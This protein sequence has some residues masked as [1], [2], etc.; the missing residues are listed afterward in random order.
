MP[1]IIIS[2]VILGV[3]F[4]LALIGRGLLVS[5]AFRISWKWGLGVLL[6]FGPVAFRLSYP[7]DAQPSRIF[8]LAALPCFLYFLVSG[9]GLPAM[10]RPFSRRPPT[11]AKSA[12]GYA[13]EK[14]APANKSNNVFTSMFQHGPTIEER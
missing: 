1:V 10:S 4:I 5:A 8:R 7:D 6:P 9:P 14:P 2:F 3:G 12:Q 11:A 13:L